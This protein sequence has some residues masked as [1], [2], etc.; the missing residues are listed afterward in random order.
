MKLGFG[1]ALIL[2]ACVSA[3]GN[4][5]P[6]QRVSVEVL[7]GPLCETREQAE[8]YI[9]EQDL[10]ESD[11][12]G[13]SDSVDVC[14][15]G[16]VAVVRGPQVGSEHGHDMAFQIIRILVVDVSTPNGIRPVKPM[17]YFTIFGVRELPV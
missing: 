15:L 16:S 11:I 9:N 14:Q 5:L 7:D 1:L 4:P 8:Q 10:Q 6:Y 3:H 2:A 17:P 13:E 12:N